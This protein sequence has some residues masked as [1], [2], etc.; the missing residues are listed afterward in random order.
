MRSDVTDARPDGHLLEAPRG[1]AATVAR[2]WS[3]A[4]LFVLCLGSFM[5][6]LD[7]TIVNVA[8]PDMLADLGGDLPAAGW[9]VSL[10]TL[11]LAVLV[12][13]FGKLGDVLGKKATYLTGVALF[14]V[15]SLACALAPDV[16]ILFVGRLLQGIGAA[17]LL[18]QTLAIITTATPE[19]RR[20]TA[21]GIHGSVSGM[22]S[23][24]GPLLGGVVT[25]TI[26]WRAI[27][28]LNVPVGL[29]VLVV[30][31]R[32]L[33]STARDRTRW[34]DWCAVLLLTIALTG[35]TYGL[36][37]SGAGAGR[38]PTAR[39]IPF[40]VALASG[41]ALAVRLRRTQ[42]RDPLIRF[43]LFRHRTYALMAWVWASVS[44]AIVATYLPLM[45]FAQSV[46]Q[47]S[48]A[49]AGL[50]VAPMFVCTVV[51]A[52]FAGGLVRR[53]TAHR[54]LAAGLSLFALGLGG[55]SLC[56]REGGQPWMFVPPLVVAGV[57]LGAT[58]ATMQ[59]IALSDIEPGDAG[60][61]SGIINGIRQLG[62]AVGGAAVVAVL[63]T[64]VS[65]VPGRDAPVGSSAWAVAYT[66]TLQWVLVITAA[67]VAMSAVL[68]WRRSARADAM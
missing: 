48:A 42:H 64:G 57:G 39:A 26:G 17:L 43:A 24:L 9:I 25:D 8:I 46:M 20:S 36:L 4:P 52:A 2:A 41:A 34:M 54:T 27:F 62:S 63:A 23:V 6:L 53:F 44:M 38:S 11:P 32:L 66:S 30:G 50:L 29:V 15:A 40:I 47:L 13:T 14:V 37:E 16:A 35:V 56:V 22:A 5:T 68:T 58:F 31:T 60:S 18:P 61:A 19:E 7:V 45:V 55:M 51:V 49:R 10:Y 1:R 12:A 67:L 3:R 65:A 33:P 59:S 21:L 28:G